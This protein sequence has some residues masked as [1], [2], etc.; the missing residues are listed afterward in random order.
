MRTL[1]SLPR[2]HPYLSVSLAAHAALLALLYHF[3]TYQ[4]QQAELRQVDA[5]HQLAS[6]ANMRKRV[7]DM[8]RIKELMRQSMGEEQGAAAEE[9][10]F[11]ATSA[12]EDKKELLALAESLSKEIEAMGRQLKAEEYAKLT[13]AKQ[14]E[15]PAP[16]EAPIPA[17]G[18]A[19][20]TADARIAALEKSARDVL[21]Q[22]QRQLERQE[23]GVPVNGGRSEGEGGHG[24][25]GGRDGSGT[26]GAG[27]PGTGA[28]TGNGGGSGTGSGIGQRIAAFVNRDLPSRNHASG[29]YGGSGP[30]LF[31]RGVGHMSAVSEAGMRKGAGRKL[32]AGGEFANRLFV[33]SWYIIG[34]F[35][36]KHGRGMFATDSYPPERA[37][38]LDAAYDGKDGRVLRWRYVETPSYPLVPPDSAEDSVYYGYT[39]LMFDE[40]QD[41]AAW[42]GADDDVQVWV[43]DQKVWAGGNV[44]KLWFF[45]QVYDTQNN[46]V[47]TYNL[48]EGKVPVRFRK[49]RNK[50]FFKLSNGP[51][52][53]FFSMVLT[54]L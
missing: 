46:F 6:H 34:P 50:L 38:I 26:A 35:E 20:A 48:S 31:D 33:N 41:L 22:R 3:G 16:P 18:D 47:P 40:A 36:G 12:P 5:S 9:P 21:S 25:G 32:G 17:P 45:N 8:E 43:N 29:R 51:T 19:A 4:I 14:L 42:I 10:R 2:R 52:R 37:V 28:G 15:A 44:N 53:V 11:D 27:T 54:P 13:G 23:R 30:E 39:E 1:F 49:G 7:T 24:A